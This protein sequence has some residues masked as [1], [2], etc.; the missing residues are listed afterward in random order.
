MRPLLELNIL[1]E[2]IERERLDVIIVAQGTCYA[3]ML[4]FLNVIQP[5]AI[6]PMAIADKT[7]SGSMLIFSKG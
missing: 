3:S 2:G 1:G 5:T 7:M 6:S 4:R